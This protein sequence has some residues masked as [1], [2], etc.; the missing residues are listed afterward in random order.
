MR[1]IIITGGFGFIGSNLILALNQRGIVPYVIDNWVNNDPKARNIKGLRFIRI[2]E[3]DIFDTASF[4][5]KPIIVCLGARVDT[6]EK[7]SEGMWSDNVETP[8]RL[9]KL[10]SKFIYASSGAVYG[11]TTDFTER[12]DGLT[13]LNDYGTTK[14]CLDTHLFGKGPV[15]PYTYG[16]RFTNVWGPREAHKGDMASVVTKA[17]L[18]KSPI[19]QGRRNTGIQ[20]K[21]SNL[22]EINTRDENPHWS[23]FKHPSGDTIRRDFI[24]VSDVADVIIH[25][26]E[27]EKIP[28]GAYNL[29]SGEAE[30]FEALVKAVEDLPIEYMDIPDHLK[31]QYQA[32]TCAKIDKLRNV[33]GYKAPFTSIQEGV[34]KTRAWM[35][36]EG[37][38][39]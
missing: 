34:E 16:L 31:A 14:Y 23:L 39:A 38:I 11:N 21:D 9:E 2:S 10:S 26:I 6:T 27:N 19:Y 28:S 1:D 3:Y 7:M 22:V 36:G 18:K 24:F 13:P 37:L 4:P 20:I 33:A 15:R 8:L 25:F 29:G 30:S 17:L 32:F 12:L 35:K 5:T